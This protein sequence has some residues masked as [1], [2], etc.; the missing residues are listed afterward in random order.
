[1]NPKETRETRR[2]PQR[3]A[4]AFPFTQPRLPRQEMSQDRRPRMQPKILTWTPPGT[5]PTRGY[6]GPGPARWLTPRTVQP[7]TAAD[8]SVGVSPTAATPTPR[9]RARDLTFIFRYILVE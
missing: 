9:R 2:P 1:R 4:R 5:K 3:P 7:S 8:A 6:S